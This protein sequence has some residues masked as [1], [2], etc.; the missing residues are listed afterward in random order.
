MASLDASTAASEAKALAM[1]AGT[2]T[3]SPASAW[4]AAQ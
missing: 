3:R 4:A 2:S 1:P